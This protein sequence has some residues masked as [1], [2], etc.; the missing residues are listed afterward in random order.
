MK[1]KINRKIV[2]Y[3]P[4]L[5]NFNQQDF[6]GQQ[7]FPVT[8]KQKVP[9]LK[10]ALTSDYQLL[11]IVNAFLTQYYQSID[12]KSEQLMQCYT[13]D[14]ILSITLNGNTNFLNGFANLNRNHAQSISKNEYVTRLVVGA[15]NITR[16]LREKFKIVGHSMKKIA[17]DIMM[18]SVGEQPVLN[19][20]SYG[21]YTNQ[22]ETVNFHNT[23]LIL[24]DPQNMQLKQIMNQQMHLFRSRDNFT[25]VQPSVDARQSLEKL[26]QLS[27]AQGMNMITT[28]FPIAKESNF[29]Y[30]V[31]V[32]KLSAMAQL[33]NTFMQQ[34]INIS[35]QELYAIC[36]LFSFDLNSM[37]IEIMNRCGGNYN[38]FVQLCIGKAKE[39]GL[40]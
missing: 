27:Q 32:K 38:N 16:I 24:F 17:F 36:M 10:I 22:R 9:P 5:E 15:T 13:N 35:F 18:W 34:G 19:V 11:K 25:V 6:E 4:K 40:L 8:V 31:T 30:D 3:F 14:S 29:D 12:N 23:F 39:N 28:V 1:E 37:N 33:N 20:V 21:Q 26:E 2:T 7:F